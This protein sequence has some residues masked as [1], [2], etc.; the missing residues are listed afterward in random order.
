MI[1]GRVVGTVWATRK[2]P[3]LARV[4]LL[5]VRPYFFYQPGHDTEQIVAVDQ[6][7]AGVG[8]DV[9]VCIGAAARWSMGGVNYPVDAA[10][11]GVVDRCRLS[12]EAFGERRGPGSMSGAVAARPL[13]FLGECVPPTLEWEGRPRPGDAVS[14]GH[15]QET[16]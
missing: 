8:D 11:L 1:L 13:R 5:V 10:V 2:D 16:P 15:D 6:V 9:V 14:R 12:R 7:D 3:R 4:K